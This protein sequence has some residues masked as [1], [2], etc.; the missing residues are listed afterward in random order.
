MAD[1]GW[2]LVTVGDMQEARSVITRHPLCVRTPLLK[3]VQD[4]F[5]Q[6]AGHK[7]QLYLKLENMQTTGSFKIRGVVNQMRHLEAQLASDKIPITMSAGNYGKAFATY[8]HQRDIPGKCMIPDTAPQSRVHLIQ[9]LGVS[10]EQMR[11]ADLQAA[12]DDYTS[13]GSH[14][15]CHPFDDIHLIAGYASVAMEILD[16]VSDPDIVLVCCGGGGLVSGVSAAIKT[17]GPS[18]CRV[19]AVE[20]EGAPSMFESFKVGKAVSRSVNTVATG[21]APPYTG[22]LTYRHC[23]EF[24]ERVL[25]VSDAEIVQSMELLYSRGLVV[26]PSGAAAMAALLN[27]H[28]P[29]VDGKKVVVVIT[30]GNVTPGE[31]NSLINKS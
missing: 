15:F 29:D 21:L 2:D 23:A 12:V 28:V 4:M 3:L 9:S 16:E 20:P 5:P 14:V 26:E 7:L 8:L 11:T 13:D 22:R 1:A 10:V 18:A 31:A 19:Y 6:L 25:L 24:V 17:L 27:G 30:G